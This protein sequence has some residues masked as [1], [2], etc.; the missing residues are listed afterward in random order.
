MVWR[1]GARFS[2][3]NVMH[4]SISVRFFPS[5][6]ILW[7]LLF[8][9]TLSGCA[10]TVLPSPEISKT[11]SLSRAVLP[12]QTF[13]LRSEVKAHESLGSQYVF[14]LFP[15]GSISAA[16]PLDILRKAVFERAVSRG[17]LPLQ[18]ESAPV[19][20]SLNRLSITAWDLL[21]V[22]KVVIHVGIGRE[23]F[24]FSRTVDFDCVTYYRY[25]FARELL[26]EAVKCTVE[27]LKQL[28]RAR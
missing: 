17:V 2:G 8:G 24:G 22:R 14:L 25:P 9:I 11:S 5:V 19:T 1:V 16:A 18:A 15:L 23:E 3:R 26:H 7:L 28:D 10:R 21:F 20:Y 27:T 6:T 13:A 12:Q 4:N